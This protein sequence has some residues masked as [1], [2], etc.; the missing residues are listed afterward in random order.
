[1]KTYNF[2]FIGRKNNAIGLTYRISDSVKAESYDEALLKLYDKYE[3]ISV[4]HY[5]VVDQS[6]LDK[7]I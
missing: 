7:L 3:L 4:M 2:D 5:S 6:V 1:M